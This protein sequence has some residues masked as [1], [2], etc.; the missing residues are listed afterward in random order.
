M[1]STSKTKLVKSGKSGNPWLVPDFKGNA[2]SFSQLSVIYLQFC[3]MWPLLCWGMVSLCPLS[4]EVFGKSWMDVEFCQ[5]FFLHLLRWSYGVAI[6]WCG[7][8]YWL[9]CTSKSDGRCRPHWKHN[10]WIFEQTLD[11]NGGEDF[12]EIFIWVQLI[13]N[14]VLILVAQQ[15]ESVIHT[16]V[17]TLF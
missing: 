13:Y 8:S 17:S 16:H 12:K 7:V 5:R 2:F 10:P 4:R 3:H 11:G 14:T 9:I 15:S 1:A 6:C